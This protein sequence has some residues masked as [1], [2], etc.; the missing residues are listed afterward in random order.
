MPSAASALVA[1]GGSAYQAWRKRLQLQ[2]H[3]RGVR[4]ASSIAAGWAESSSFR[5]R[6]LRLELARV[7]AEDPVCLVLPVSRQCRL[8]PPRGAQAR[9]LP[10]VNCDVLAGSDAA[11]GIVRQLPAHNAA[12]AEGHASL[13]QGVLMGVDVAEI[14]QG[15]LPLQPGDVVLLASDGLASLPASEVAAVCTAAAKQ[16]AEHVANALVAR[17]DA[18]EQEGQD[19]AM[20]GCGWRDT[21]HTQ[22]SHPTTVCVEQR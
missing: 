1:T 3:L 4:H 21:E 12:L 13:V 5:E 14:A 16:G 2:C 8:R 20:S 10:V 17:I 18:L 7:K 22:T 11:D 19:N 15:E 9:F 6:K